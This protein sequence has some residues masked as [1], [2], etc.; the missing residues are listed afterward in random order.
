MAIRGTEGYGLFERTDGI[1]DREILYST[2]GRLLKGGI[3]RQGEGLVRAGTL[4][5]IDPASKKWLVYDNTNAVN[6]VQT[7][8]VTG[9][10]TDG[11]FSLGFTPVP[12]GDVL[13][14]TPI[15]H[16][17][18]ATAVSDALAA[19][20]N[21]GVGNVTVSGSAGGPYTVTFVAA[22]GSRDVPLLTL[23]DNSL[24]G[25]SAPSVAVVQA[26]AGVPGGKVAAG[27]CANDIDVS[28]RDEAVNI[29][30][31]G[32][33]KTSQLIGL[34]ADAITALSIKQ[35]ADYGWSRIG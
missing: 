27:I 33:F 21:I 20:S 6:E 4:L 16:D 35:N 7:V 22:L 17:A 10:P 32:V 5:A 29:Y 26:T 9:T 15:D 28:D 14:T 8:T 2:E 23:E 13:V 3:L 30:F 18:P 11:T 1:E 19:L 24:T 31:K 12:G 25:G 34:D